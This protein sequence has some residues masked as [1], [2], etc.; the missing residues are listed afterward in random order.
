MM[1]SGRCLFVDVF[2][3]TVDRD[4]EYT[5]A[6]RIL[7]KLHTSFWIESRNF[8]TTYKRFPSKYMNKSK[9]E[10][11]QRARSITEEFDTIPCVEKS[12]FSHVSV[13]TPRND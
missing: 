10:K 13:A 1:I 12:C 7:L 2:V 11:Q 4:D 6:R 3:A 5:V 8:M 9:A